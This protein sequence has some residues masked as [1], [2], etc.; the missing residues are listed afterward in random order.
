MMNNFQGGTPVV[1]MPVD[2]T[3]K[4][5]KLPDGS[6]IQKSLVGII[7]VGNGRTLN[8][9]PAPAYVPPPTEAVSYTSKKGPS[10]K[11][12]PKVKPSW[13][14]IFLSLENASLKCLKKEKDTKPKEEILLQMGGWVTAV[15]ASS[16]KR[17]DVHPATA[18]G[19]MQLMTQNV[20]QMM[21]QTEGTVG[22]DFSMEIH[23]P[24]ATSHLLETLMNTSVTS[25]AFGGA[26]KMEADKAVTYYFH[27]ESARE[28][29]EWV[30]AVKNNFQA[31]FSSK[32]CFEDVK[33][34]FVSYLKNLGVDGS[35]F[36]WKQI[37]HELYQ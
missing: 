20:G 34:V 23:K 11:M 24:A 32:E 8:L 36:D 22:K 27:F 30:A 5:V 9:T 4:T 7:F 31:Y 10:Q 18:G 19:M 21:S 15:D 17:K 33:K 12:A 26:K 28:R 37:L 14:K 16:P 29:D 2:Q 35:S 3:M 25:L 13:D 6:M 1:A